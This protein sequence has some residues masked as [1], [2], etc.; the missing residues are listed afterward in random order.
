MGIRKITIC[1]KRNDCIGCGSC[2][3]LAPNSWTLNDDGLSTLNGSEWRNQQF[4]VGEIDEIELQANREA[5]S[6]C[7]VNIIRIVRSK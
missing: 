4:M 5:A 6:M 7:P 2:V 1:H 3:F